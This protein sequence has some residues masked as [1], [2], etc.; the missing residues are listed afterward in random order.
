MYNH[1]IKKMQYVHFIVI[2]N[3]ILNNSSPKRYDTYAQGSDITFGH[4]YYKSA[5]YLGIK[6]WNILSIHISN[7]QTLDIFRTGIKQ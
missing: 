1:L 5:V 4:P 3:E 7:S 2:L 6:T